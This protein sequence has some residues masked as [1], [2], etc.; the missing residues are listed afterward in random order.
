MVA[1][2]GGLDSSVAAAILK[3]KGFDVI[4][5]TMKLWPEEDCGRDKGPKQCCSLSGIEDARAVAA[6]ID[7]PY[8][9]FDFSKEFKE[10]VIDYFCTEYNRGATPNPCILCNQLLKFDRLFRKAR[11]LGCNHIAT[12]HYAQVGYNRI[13]KKYYVREGRDKTKDQS[14]FLAFLPQDALSRTIFPL[15]DLTKEKARRLAK[16]MGFGVHNK[17]SSQEICFVDEHYVDY[18]KRKGA[19]EN[20]EGDILDTAGKRIGRHKGVH[21]YTIGQRKGLGV[22]YREP[23]YVVKIDKARNAIIA[24]TKREVKKRVFIAAEAQWM[25]I[26]GIKKSASFLTKIRYSHKKTPAAV[27]KAG[28]SELKVAFKSPQ[29]AITPGQAVVFYKHDMVMGGAWISHVLE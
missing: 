6:K 7:I 29:E 19:I 20:G 21:F 16:K 15:G 4:G 8:Y 13:N 5:A 1:M 9:V 25:A 12:G 22:A 10:R 23:L 3:K 24:G 26:D 18:L 2:S 14:Y 27:E 11:E 17:P 28:N